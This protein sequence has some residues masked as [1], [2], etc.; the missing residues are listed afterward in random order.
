M[1]T[2]GSLTSKYK[3]KFEKKFFG[4]YG[5]HIVHIFGLNMY[6]NYIYFYTKFD[7]NQID[8]TIFRF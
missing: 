3:Q 4:F 2:Y 5:I 6:F 7:N 1:W 8:I